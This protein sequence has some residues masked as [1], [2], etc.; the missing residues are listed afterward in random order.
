M[1]GFCGGQQPEH[2]LDD[3]SCCFAGGS[4]NEN[5]QVSRT[6]HHHDDDDK[7][8]PRYRLRCIDSACGCKHCDQETT[9]VMTDDEGD[10]VRV[11][12]VNECF[13]ALK[14]M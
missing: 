1:V 13:C 2:V 8:M 7:L 10:I 6:R 11:K 4:Q 3:S 12:V 5:L 9:G 14:S